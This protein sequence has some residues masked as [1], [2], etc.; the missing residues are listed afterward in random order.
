MMNI[1]YPE[2]DFRFKEEA[3]KKFIYD[4]VRK[5]WFQITE[6]E[7]V[8]Q[9]FIR[10]LIHQKKYPVSLFAVEKEMKLGELSKR[11]DILVYDRNHKPWMMIECK[12]PEIK[13]TEKVIEQ[14]LNYHISIPC[15]Y[16]IITNGKDTFGWHKQNAEM[17][18]IEELPIW[19]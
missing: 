11:F 18:L 2:P 10:V 16:L 15:E 9:N 3:G 17:K 19:A 6:E 14:I 13:L 1:N 5:Q 4:I 7:W 8:R 12:A